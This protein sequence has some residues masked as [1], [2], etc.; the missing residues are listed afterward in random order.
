MPAPPLIISLPS[1]HLD[2]INFQQMNAGLAGPHDCRM[3]GLY[4]SLH[5]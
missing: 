3:S 4:L 5:L 1:V 2:I